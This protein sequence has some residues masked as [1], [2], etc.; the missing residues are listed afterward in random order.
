MKSPFAISVDIQRQLTALLKK[1]AINKQPFVPK[2][3]V[4]PAVMQRLR[5]EDSHI[6]AELQAKFETKLTFVSELHRHPE[7][8]AIIDAES[9][10]TLCSQGGNL[11]PV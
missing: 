6:L 8:F 7:S 2:I 4:A 3:I 1:A 11:P 5:T 10:E 9:G